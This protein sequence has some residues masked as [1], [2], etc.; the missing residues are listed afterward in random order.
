MYAELEFRAEFAGSV[1]FV[2]AFTIRITFQKRKRP[3][4]LD[5]TI[6]ICADLASMYTLLFTKDSSTEEDGWSDAMENFLYRLGFAPEAV[7]CDKSSKLFP[8]FRDHPGGKPPLCSG[9]LLWAAAG[10]TP[11][12]HHSM[13]GTGRAHIEAEIKVAARC[14]HAIAVTRCLNLQFAG[15]PAP[16]YWFQDGNEFSSIF[17]KW[18][19][20][21]NEQVLTRA[22]KP[23]IQLWN[24][25]ESA[26]WRESRVLTS[27]VVVKQK[28]LRESLVV[29]AENY[30]M[31]FMPAGL[32]VS[33]TK[34]PSLSRILEV[35]LDWEPFLFKIAE[36]EGKQAL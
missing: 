22:R 34:R 19:H 33:D 28:V 31:L 5:K 6:Y 7:I 25:G 36:H 15:A 9:A 11:V 24:H 30:R 23:R 16:M 29:A 8:D 32:R 12:V 17:S 27:E 3:Q 1:F 20:R 26:R 21:I 35:G 14:L 13:R 2:D 10:A 4:Y 18:E